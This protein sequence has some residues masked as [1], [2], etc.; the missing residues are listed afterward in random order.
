MVFIFLAGFTL[1]SSFSSYKINRTGL[2][3]THNPRPHNGR[4]T[5]VSGSIPG[6][7]SPSFSNSLFS[8]SVSISLE[9]SCGSGEVG[10]RVAKRFQKVTRNTA[11]TRALRE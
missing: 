2:L 4:L 11:P 1:F 6:K 8:S 10:S 9:N 3:G 7:V 5:L